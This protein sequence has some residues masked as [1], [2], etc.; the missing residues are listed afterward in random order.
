MDATSVA[1]CGI[2]PQTTVFHRLPAEMRALRQWCVVPNSA[3]DKAPR[4]VDGRH[5]SVTDPASWTDFDTASRVAEA[6][7]WLIGFVFTATDPFACI[8]LDVVN[9]TTQE[10]KGQ[11]IDPAKWTTPAEM[12]RLQKIVQAFDS[13]SEVSRS[14]Q[15]L[16]ILLNGNIG[17]G[18]RR[19]GVEVYS[20]ERFLICTG[21]VYA[22]RP[23]A[24]HS[25]LLSTLVGEMK[26]LVPE[27]ALWG[28]PSPNWSLADQALL[29]Q[30]ELGRLFAGDW[31][32]RYPSQSEADLALVKLLMPECDSPRECWETFCLSNLGKRDKA[33]RHDYARRTVSLALQHHANDAAQA[34]HGQALAASMFWKP[35]HN[36]GHFRLLSDD[37]LASFPTPR[38]KVKGIVPETGIGT[39]FGQ[40]GTFKS[41]LALDLLAH[42]ANGH[43]WFGRKV[44]AAPTVYVPFEGQG[45]IPKR[46]DAWRHAHAAQGHKATTNIRFIMEPMNLRQQAD[47]DKLVATM[48]AQGWLGGVL[49]I[50]TLA[51]AGI[52][53]DENTSQGMGEMIAI[54]QELQ[55]RLGGV[56]LVVHHSGKTE[57]AGMRGHSS[58]H[59]ALDFAVRCWR[60]DDW[61][62]HEAQFVLD[63]VK[64][65]ENELWFNFA[66]QSFVIGKDEDGDPITSLSVYPTPQETAAAPSETA[67]AA[68]DDAF[69]DAWVRRSMP[70]GKQ[71]TGRWLESE[72]V[73]VKAE[74]N[75][76][77]KRLRDAIA[78]LKGIGKLE[79][80]PGGPSG[81]KWLRAVDV[82]PVRGQ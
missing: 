23:L 72:L 15:G 24:H 65:G 13:Y 71:P 58:L 10:Q 59:G 80:T 42:I 50:D 19:D 36:P 49:C 20:Q 25:E 61:P 68:V 60:D 4:T 39:I 11:P 81:A 35:T 32:G 33:K 9:A 56:V 8:D 76:T 18:R 14:G 21:R 77:Q 75:L 46:V 43:Y 78:R 66:M 51:Q 82:M 47:R 70:E 52:G 37:D 22:D 40:S 67:I 48:T 74:R 57:K 54:F 64:D 3:T 29:D 53:I 69:V 30:G 16:H 31:Q 41:F 17:D 38:W 7:G 27:V 34:Q 73:N 5:A 45:G 6:K 1:D 44:K 28:D 63:K 79:E 26:P 12:E 62:K 55:L 2:G